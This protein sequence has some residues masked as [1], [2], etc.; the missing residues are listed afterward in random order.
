M[1]YVCGGVEMDRGPQMNNMAVINVVTW[2]FSYLV[3]YEALNFLSCVYFVK[4]MRFSS[5][6]LTFILQARKVFENYIIIKY[7]AGILE[8]EKS[9]FFI[10]KTFR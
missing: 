6:L 8:F 5:Y 10:S 1:W 9:L 3:I 7:N 2:E 4:S